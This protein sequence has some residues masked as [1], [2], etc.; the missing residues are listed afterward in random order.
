MFDVAFGRHALGRPVMAPPD[1]PADRAAALQNA[2]IETV[3]DPA[4]LAEAA[5]QGLDINVSTGD[6]V[7][8]LLKSFFA[9]PKEVIERAEAAVRE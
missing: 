7:R 1:I 2:F 4:F 5:R 9:T 8:A 6:E 3:K